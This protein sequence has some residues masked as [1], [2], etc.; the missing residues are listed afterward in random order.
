MVVILKHT[1]VMQSI[2][3][4]TA[5][6]GIE[7]LAQNAKL[8][9]N[10]VAFSD[11]ESGDEQSVEEGADA[12]AA[13]LEAAAAFSDDSLDDEAEL[14]QARPQWLLS[15]LSTTVYYCLLLSISVH[16]CMC[17]HIAL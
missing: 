2:F 7:T 5:V 4:R 12:D 3:G 6:A 1:H 10:G 9:A 11:S 17:C 14:Q 8:S 13:E 15:L 16:S